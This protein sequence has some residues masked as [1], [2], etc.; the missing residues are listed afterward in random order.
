M[1]FCFGLVVGWSSST[2][3]KL[4]GP[5]TPLQSGPL[6]V[7]EASW[8]SSIMCIGGALATIIYGWSS[9]K[10]GRRA[11]LLWLGPPTMVRH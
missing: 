10:F 8:T 6:T 4:Q 1:T 5:Y 3:V 2:L 7:D 11:S 9:E